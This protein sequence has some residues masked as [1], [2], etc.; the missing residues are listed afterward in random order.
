MQTVFV[1]YD[2]VVATLSILFTYNVILASFIKLKIFHTLA[3][4]K[5]QPN[6]VYTFVSKFW[7]TDVDKT[8][9]N[10]KLALNILKTE[11]AT[12]GIL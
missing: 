1:H 3:A 2:E 11:A 10:R 5:F 12:R 9:L 6:F 7:I 8:V 4:Q